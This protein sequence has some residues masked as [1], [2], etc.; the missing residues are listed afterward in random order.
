MVAQEGIDLLRSHVVQKR[1]GRVVKGRSSATHGHI[2][3]TCCRRQAE[4]ATIRRWIHD[5]DRENIVVADHRRGWEGFQRAREESKHPSP[6]S[7]TESHRE[8]ELGP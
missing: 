2:G 5:S 1:D 4:G 7:V 3:S 8:D 6:M